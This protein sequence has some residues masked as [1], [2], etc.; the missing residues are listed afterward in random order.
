MQHWGGA[1]WVLA[2][3]MIVGLL[4]PPLVRGARLHDA[5]DTTSWQGFYA[6]KVLDCCVL[7]LILLWGGF[8][9]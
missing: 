5:R 1:Q 3:W 9:N 4:C 8:W 6:S 7:A 2:T